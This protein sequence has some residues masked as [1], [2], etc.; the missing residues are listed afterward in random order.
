MD[1]HLKMDAAK[2]EI[3]QTKCCPIEEWTGFLNDKAVGW[4]FKYKSTGSPW[5][6]DINQGD[7]T[8]LTTEHADFNIA[9]ETLKTHLQTKI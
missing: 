7:G 1:K 2:A 8:I 3:R 9:Y 4:I 5:V 6:V